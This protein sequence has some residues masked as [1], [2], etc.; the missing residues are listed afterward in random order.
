MISEWTSRYYPS[1]GSESRVAT[2]PLLRYTKAYISLAAVIRFISPVRTTVALFV[3][4][5]VK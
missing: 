2:L 1:N 3:E 4:L 5:I